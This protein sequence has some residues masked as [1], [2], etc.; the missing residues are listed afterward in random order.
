[1]KHWLPIILFLQIGTTVLAQQIEQDCVNAIP[2]C[3]DEY[4][5][6]NSYEGTG[7]IP[8]EIND[9]ISCLGT[10]ERNDVWYIFTVAEAGD[11]SFTITPNDLSEDYDW[12]VYNL[13]N[14]QC[15]DIY[16]IPNIEV[17]CNYSYLAGITGATGASNETS[18]GGGSD[19]NQNALIPVQL[20]ETYVINVSNYESSDLD[21]Y[22]INLSNSTADIFDNISP[23]ITNISGHPEFIEPIE[24]GDNLVYITFSEYILCDSLGVED[25]VLVGPNGFEY[26]TTEVYGKE[27]DDFIGIADVSRDRVFVLKFEP[28]FFTGG[29]YEVQIVSPSGSPSVLDLCSNIIATGTD[30][31]ALRD[32]FNIPDFTFSAIVQDVLV[33]DGTP[34][35]IELDNTIFNAT[36][37]WYDNN[38]VVLGNE[39]ATGTS[40]NV[41]N[42]LLSGGVQTFY[43]T[44][45]LNTGCVSQVETLMV[46]TYLP[47]DPQFTYNVLNCETGQVEFINQ[48][49]VDTSL[50]QTPNYN[51]NF[52]DQF[53]TG[54]NQA[55]QTFSYNASG[56]FMV[57]LEADYGLG[58]NKNAITQEVIIPSPAVL[59][60]FEAT[61]DVC[62]QAIVS[63]V[64]TFQSY[65]WDW[66]DGTVETGNA[67][68]THFY[69][70]PGTYQIQLSVTK[71]YPSIPCNFTTSHTQS[72]EVSEVVQAVGF[73][74]TG[75]G[76][77][78]L[79]VDVTAIQEA[80]EYIWDWGDGNQD[81]GKEASHTYNVAG[82]YDINLLVNTNYANCTYTND[83]TQKVNVQNIPIIESVIASL[84]EVF[85]GQSLQLSYT[86]NDTRNIETVYWEINDGTNTEGENITHTFDMVGTY[87]ACV[88]I[89][90]EDSGCLSEAVCKNINVIS[91]LW[92]DVPNA[93][94]PNNDGLNDHLKIEGK[95]IASLN[96]QIF[97]RW[98]ELVFQ[99]SEQDIAWDGMHNGQIQEMDVFIYTLEVEFVDGS[100]TTQEGNITLIR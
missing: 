29:D 34:V 59:S 86:S 53:G 68:M 70:A 13:T 66:G 96:W 60:N 63:V 37:Q 32:T 80:D 84:D 5:Q 91:N 16:N 24:C 88:Q 17:S 33:C 62:N 6:E 38:G 39:I 56:S 74:I 95:G 20:G 25:V 72:I 14:H 7:F 98:G 52:G 97:N 75:I 61:P 35:N 43:L 12:A 99:T 87:E 78:P 8:E 92:V 46:E 67:S 18:V 90:T 81:T 40:Y 93:F 28:P 76:C 65:T 69:D 15:E 3:Q 22:T 27:C 64:D 4:Y 47:P 82:D 11:L 73:D 45:T 85:V 83:T 100:V 36:Y 49:I 23:E 48:T 26:T 71:D 54:S 77:T 94:S 30:D 79:T 19:E 1:M 89:E 58:C 55:N 42:D 9:N 57:S 50:N 21:G 10:G 41:T 2:I 44:E 31:V 51:W